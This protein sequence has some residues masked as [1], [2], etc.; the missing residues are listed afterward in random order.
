MGKKKAEPAKEELPRVLVTNPF[1]GICHMQVCAVSDA[2]DEEI[3]RV[4]N[5]EN[6]S[7]TSQGWGC[8][9]REGDED[10]RARP[11]QCGDHP[12]RTHFLVS[13]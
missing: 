5:L 13:C 7:G 1:V 6:M 11:V 9:H 3:L 10:E 4:S 2:T 8:V 12:E